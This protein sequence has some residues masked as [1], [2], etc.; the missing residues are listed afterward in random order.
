MV[1]GEEGCSA[2]AGQLTPDPG[3]P[4]IYAEQRI[5]GMTAEGT[6]DLRFDE[7][8]LREE[9]MF[10]HLSFLLLRVPVAR[11]S[12]FQDIADIDVASAEANPLDEL[13]E[14]L[15][16]PPYK[17]FSL[18]VFFLSRRLTDKDQLRVRFTLAED[19]VFACCGK[20]AFTALA[21]LFPE[22]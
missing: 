11:W 18:D 5:V 20:G 3:D 16:G 6:D 7:L 14:E 17:W 1:C 8:K 22:F 10:A 19:N 21:N 13:V 9:I 15:A 4:L 12:A 2:V